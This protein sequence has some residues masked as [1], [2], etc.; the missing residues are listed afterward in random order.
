M[1]KFLD[2]LYV[3]IKYGIP[4]L[5]GLVVLALCTN[6]LISMWESSVSSALSTDTAVGQ[7]INL[8]KALG[9]LNLTIFICILFFCWIL[10]MV[11]INSLG[12]RLDKIEKLIKALKEKG[13]TTNGRKNK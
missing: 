5:I 12:E 6:A 8:I 13:E 9:E 10:L 1:K 11:N 4:P 7:I 2:E 3:I